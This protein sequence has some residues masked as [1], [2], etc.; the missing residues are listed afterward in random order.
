M[1][2]IQKLNWMLEQ[3]NIVVDRKGRLVSDLP[4]GWIGVGQLMINRRF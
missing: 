3:L 1:R 2:L 4:S